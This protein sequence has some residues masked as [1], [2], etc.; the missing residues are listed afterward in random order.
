MTGVLLTNLL[1]SFTIYKLN[2]LLYL[3]VG[4]TLAYLIFFLLKPFSKRSAVIAI[5]NE[6]ISLLF[7][8]FFGDEP[9]PQIIR[10]D[11]IKEYL[12]QADIF[13]TLIQ[14]KL[15]TG[16]K[17]RFVHDGQD[18]K[19][20]QF[21]AF[22]NAL[23]KEITSINETPGL[24]QILLAKTIYESRKGLFI[25]I[26]LVTGMFFIPFVDIALYYPFLLTRVIYLL[27]FYSLGFYFV[28]MVYFS[29]K[30]NK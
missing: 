30:I 10:W 24:K 22:Q 15:V 11:E 25:A 13:Y 6:Y 8:T 18:S 9:K 3:V 23:N 16:K 26:C 28:G 12:T 4:F 2:T 1:I 5:E 17:V 27:A 19:I 14:F 29:R 21:A 20:D 7:P